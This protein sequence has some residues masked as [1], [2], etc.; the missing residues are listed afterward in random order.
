MKQSFQTGNESFTLADSL[1]NVVDLHQMTLLLF[2]TLFLLAM[3][4]FLSPLP[5]P[6]PFKTVISIMYTVSIFLFLLN[7]HH[8]ISYCIVFLAMGNSWTF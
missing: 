4:L 7:S 2:S 6:C 5:N 1:E 8:D 3:C